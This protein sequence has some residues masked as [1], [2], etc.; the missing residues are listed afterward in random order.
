MRQLI[1]ALQFT[2]HA[3]PADKTAKVLKAATT[4]PGASLT[5]TIGPE[6]V[7]RELR[8]IAGGRVAFKSTVT[9]EDDGTFRE[10]G[11]IAFGEN[12]HHPRFSTVGARYLGPSADPNLSQGA[13]NWRVDGGEGQFDGAPGLTT[14]IFFVSGTGE[15]TDNH[16]SVIFMRPWMPPRGM[17]EGVGHGSRA[18]QARGEEDGDD[19]RSGAHRRRGASR[20]V[21]RPV[22]VPAR[23][24]LPPGGALARPPP[25]TRRRAW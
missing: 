15:V 2:G 7:R 17:G 23:G 19:R 12:G 22:P 1:Y 14:S 9:F 25:C 13:V 6:G 5:S 8:P 18:R 10:A 20:A 11:S 3:A 21:H 4:A 16:F 24:A